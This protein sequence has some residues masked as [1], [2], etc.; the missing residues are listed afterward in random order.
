M[1]LAREGSR[2]ANVHAPCAH[3]LEGILLGEH[4]EVPEGEGR[5]ELQVAGLWVGAGSAEAD[6]RRGLEVAVDGDAGLCVDGS[7]VDGRGVRGPAAADAEELDLGHDEAVA[8]AVFAHDALEVGEALEVEDLLGW[9]LAAHARVPLVVALD[10]ADD[11]TPAV[12]KEGLLVVGGVAGDELG[13]LA[14]SGNSLDSAHNHVCAAL[15][16]LERSIDL[17]GIVVGADVLERS[18]VLWLQVLAARLGKV[19]SWD[20]NLEKRKH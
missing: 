9:G 7:G 16:N 17:V 2:A 15:R 4:V 20:G 1:V 11:A 12:A 13:L 6:G 10:E 3:A 18:L 14:D 8:A 5:G 19:R